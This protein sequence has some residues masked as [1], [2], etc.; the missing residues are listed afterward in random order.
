MH[1]VDEIIARSSNDIEDDDIGYIGTHKEIER[2]GQINQCNLIET[3]LI[4][5]KIIL[6]DD[7]DDCSED[8]DDQMP[9]SPQ[10]A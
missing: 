3:P 9:P 5:S 10:P 1:D 8:T 7:I 2:I 4:E 6:D